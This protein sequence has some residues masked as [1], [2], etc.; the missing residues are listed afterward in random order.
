MQSRVYASVWYPSVCLSQH[1]PCSSQLCCCD[2][3]SRRYWLIAALHRAAQRAVGECWECHIFSVCSAFS[4]K[5]FSVCLQCF[6]LP[7]VLWRCWLG[8]KKGI[9][10][11]KNIR[12]VWCWCGCLSGARCRLAL[13]PSWCHCHP[14]SCFSK[15][16]IGFT[17][18]VLAHLGSPGQRAVKRVCVCVVP[19][20]LWCCWLGGR[21]GIR[22]V[23]NW[24]VGCWR[25]YLSGAR[26]RLAYSPSD[27][28]ATHCLLL[29]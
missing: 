10:P 18:L 29:Q 11:V 3:S 14:L 20:V 4:G 9:R 24:V 27:A 8:G 23:K 19:S 7:S 15:I 28:T 6:D 17:F 22:P 13:W 5:C 16:Q 12:V 25:G 2:L 21:K 1:G 26:S